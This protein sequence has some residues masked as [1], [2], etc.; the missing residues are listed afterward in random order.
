MQRLGI[1]LLAVAAIALVGVW[2]VRVYDT[3]EGRCERG[4]LD[5]CTVLERRAA[6]AAQAEQDARMDE[7]QAAIQAAVAAEAERALLGQCFLR[8]ADHD[9]TIRVSGAD[10]DVTCEW[11]R[12]PEVLG[13]DWQLVDHAGAEAVICTIPYGG[14]TGV[15]QTLTV[16]DSGGATY[17]REQCDAFMSY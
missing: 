15:E 4:D 5:A 14:P 7:A 6:A 16:L 9:A 2:Y 1:G 8:L 12:D 3:A 10:A 13:R 17:G 11:L